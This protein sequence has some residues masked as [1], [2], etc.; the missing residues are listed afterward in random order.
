MIG[1]LLLRTDALLDLTP[2]SVQFLDGS[3]DRGEYIRS[4]VGIG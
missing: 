4:I 3:V 1:A 2:Q